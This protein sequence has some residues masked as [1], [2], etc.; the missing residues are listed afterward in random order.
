MKKVFAVDETNAPRM[1]YI[2]RN[3]LW[4]V[5]EQPQATLLDVPRM[6]SDAGLSPAGRSAGCRIR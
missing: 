6:L 1:L 4:H 2:L 3:V 5:I